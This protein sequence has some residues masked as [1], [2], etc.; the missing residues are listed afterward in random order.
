MTDL[1]KLSDHTKKSVTQLRAEIEKLREKDTKWKADHPNSQ[2]EQ[3]INKF[4]LIK[5][6]LKKR[7]KSLSFKETDLDLEA[8]MLTEIA[9]IKTVPVIPTEHT[10]KEGALQRPHKCKY[11]DKPAT[12][13]IIWAEGRAF[14]PVCDNHKEKAIHQIEKINNDEVE[15]ILPLP[16]KKA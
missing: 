13:A 2:N 12:L 10:F 9:K 6:E 8:K 16:E 1:D 14:I 7:K 3:I 15:E 11:C 4:L 5:A